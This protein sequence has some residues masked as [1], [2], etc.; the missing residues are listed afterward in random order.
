M[1]SLLAVAI[2][3]TK[4]RQPS[5]KEQTVSGG[6]IADAFKKEI[7]ESEINHRI[8]KCCN[9]IPGDDVIGYLNP[10][11]ETI[12]IHKLRCPNSVKLS[13][14]HG[15]LMVP[16]KWTTYKMFSFL[17]KIA[18]QGI[19][20]PDIYLQITSL[21]TEELNVNIRTFNMAS[22]DGIFEGTIELYV[23]DTGDLDNLMK[24]LK[25]LKGVETV[26][27]LEILDQSKE[28]V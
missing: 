2:V 1:D 19:D 13:S 15:D 5:N 28:E 8:A 17:A 27:R 12:L 9:P 10:L 22:H 3:R 18:I 14:S 23:H 25:R 7:G 11:N 24:R 20:R 4:T 6:I 26:K 16:V 21:I